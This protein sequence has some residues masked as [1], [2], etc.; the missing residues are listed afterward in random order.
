MQAPG[1]EGSAESTGVLALAVYDDRSG[2][3]LALFAGGDSHGAGGTNRSALAKWPC[4]PAAPDDPAAHH[5]ELADG[6]VTNQASQTVAGTV[7]ASPP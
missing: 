7:T 5:G 6:A 4:R 2:T 3:G 1:T